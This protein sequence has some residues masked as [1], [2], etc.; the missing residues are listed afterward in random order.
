MIA[1]TNYESDP[2]VVREAEAAVDGGFDVDVIALRRGDQPDIEVLRGVRVVRLRQ[3]RYRGGSRIRYA[4]AYLEF[5]FRC[6]AKS[7]LLFPSRRYRVAHVNNMPD[8]L[9]WAVAPLKLFGCRVILD[10]H[11]PMPETFGAKFAGADRSALYRILLTAERLSV[12]L[13]DRTITVSEPVRTGILLEHGY[14]P[15]KIGVV[16]NFADDDLFRLQPYAPF[17][18]RVRFVFHGTIL[19]R[20]GLGTLVEALAL[21]RDRARIHVRIIGEGDFSSRL[22][23]LIVSH[24]LG[25]VV[26]FR[27]RSYPIREIP[28]LIS[29]CHVGL[30]PLK[31]SAVANYALPLKLVEYTCLGLPS[32]SIRSA[33]I[34][35][36]VRPDECVFFEA[37]NVRALAQAIDDVAASP[38]RL[39]EYRGKLPIVRERLLWSGEKRKY[40]AMLQEL[41]G[42]RRKGEFGATEHASE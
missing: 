24:D 26:E 16:A 13:S 20:N 30:V 41:A 7:L 1:Y 35:Y 28:G 39:L 33:A 25:D 5:F 12:W 32:I 27:N 11:D 4:L 22:Q 18:G 34:D 15:G 31:L 3:E 40:I 21:V 37:G 10:I 14:A 8:A 23:E 42:Q 6:L 2:R 9:V 36:Y 38:E 19:E 17:D 29:D